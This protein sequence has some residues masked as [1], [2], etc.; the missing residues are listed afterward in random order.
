MSFDPSIL[1]Y[2]QPALFA[3]GT[4]AAHSAGRGRTAHHHMSA[5][6]KEILAV[7]V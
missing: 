6:M 2:T 7:A 5:L 4:N 1:T 3:V